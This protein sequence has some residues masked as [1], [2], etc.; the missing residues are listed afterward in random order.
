M[1]KHLLFLTSVLLLSCNSTSEIKT[2][3]SSNYDYDEVEFI[4]ESDFLT[5]KEI[6][7]LE[8]A[9][10]ILITEIS[11]LI[12]HKERFYILD[13][14]QRRFFAF[15]TQ[16]HYDFSLY[17]LGSGPNELMEFTDFSLDHANDKIELYSYTEGKKLILELDG[18]IIG[19]ENFRGTSWQEVVKFND[20]YLIYRT[21]TFKDNIGTGVHRTENDLNYKSIVDINKAQPTSEG[22]I[23]FNPDFFPNMIS[24]ANGVGFIVPPTNL[25]KTLKMDYY[26]KEGLTNFL[27]IELNKKWIAGFPVIGNQ[28]QLV[29]IF[30]HMEHVNEGLKPYVFFGANGKMFKAKS[31]VNDFYVYPHKFIHINEN[32]QIIAYHNSE[33][34]TQIQYSKMM[35]YFKREDIDIQVNQTMVDKFE[36]IKK[37]VSVNGNP[38]LLVMEVKK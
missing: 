32:N 28:F 38:I 1:K 6:I 24:S 2:G 3:T 15:S 35:D 20:E 17:P 37:E 33:E 4:K 18:T 12:Q 25:D 31:Y 26:N 16:G 14:R 29:H 8:S 11:K 22:G 34:L 9:K 5:I 19:K 36:K 27:T 10:D 7:P 23:M 30:P 21:A 13:T